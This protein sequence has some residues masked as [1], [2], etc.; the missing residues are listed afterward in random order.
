MGNYKENM[1]VVKKFLDDN[2]WHYDMQDHGRVGVF[3]GGVG[4]FKGLYNSFRFILFVGDDELQNY[5]MFP[6]SAKDK[7]PEI[8]EFIT[9][10]NYGLHMGCFELDFNDGEIRYKM[11]ISNTALEA[12]PDDEIGRIMSIPCSTID[13]Y[14]S[15]IIGVLSGYE[16]P[17]EAVKRC[18]END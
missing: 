14:S 6:A 1:E 7:L 17:E 2:D 18:E 13:T 3:M 4:G 8:A 15:G 16:E 5:A 11:S 12:N 9:R 10:A